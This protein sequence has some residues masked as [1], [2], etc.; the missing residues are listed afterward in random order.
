MRLESGTSVARGEAQMI[1][2]HVVDKA[3]IRKSELQSPQILMIY[4]IDMQIAFFGNAVEQ[5]GT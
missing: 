3:K 4:M 5:G 1:M 2:K